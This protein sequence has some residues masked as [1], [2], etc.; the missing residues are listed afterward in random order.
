MA[1]MVHRLSGLALACF[2]PLH[3]LALGLAIDGAA[4]IDSF[5]AWTTN[6]VVKLAETALVFLLAVHMLGGLRVLV[7]ENL[8]W[9][10][11]QK[12]LVTAAL[13]AAALAAIAFLA[14]AA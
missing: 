11:G 12:H 3:F 6:P 9:H 4:R 5:L 2:L 7:I 14:R 1:A 10:E 8:P 13:A